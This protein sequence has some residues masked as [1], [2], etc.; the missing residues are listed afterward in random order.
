MNIPA[1]LTLYS[2][3]RHFAQST[4]TVLSGSFAFGLAYATSAVLHC[5]QI[6]KWHKEIQANSA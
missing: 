6:K 4:F 5:P 3:V 2:R 1:V